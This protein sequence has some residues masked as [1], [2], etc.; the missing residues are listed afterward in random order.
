MSTL[1]ARKNFAVGSR[2]VRQGDL[3]DAK[4]PI[5][6]GR[7]VLFDEPDAAMARRVRAAGG[8]ERATA[9]PGERRDV[10]VPKKAAATKPTK[11]AGD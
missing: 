11:K 4:D 2:I 7:E 1:I 6:K 10:T 3:V 8:T 9:A 5:V